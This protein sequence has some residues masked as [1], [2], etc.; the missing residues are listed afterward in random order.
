MLSFAVLAA[1][2]LAE[3]LFGPGHLRGP[4]QSVTHLQSFR[5]DLL[6]PFLPN[7]NQLLAPAAAVRAAAAATRPTIR[8]GGSAELGGY[9]GIPLVVLVL[10]LIVVLRRD[11]VI[12]ALSA[13]ATAA[14]LLSLGN[15]LEVDGRITS[16]PLP[17]AV[18][19]HLP[20]LD[21]TVPARFGLFVALFT[22]MV[23]AIGI[24]RVLVG[25]LMIRGRPAPPAVVAG[26]A[27][28]AVLT[29]VA[30]FPRTPLVKEEPALQGA[31]TS[32]LERDVPANAV[33]LTYPY[34]DPPYDVAMLWQASAKMRFRLMG[35]Y[36]TVNGAASAGQYYPVL[37]EPSFVQEELTSVEAGRSL[38]YPAVDP[39]TDG[40]AALCSYLARYGVGAVVFA[41]IAY[42]PAGPGVTAVARLFT[43]AL[44]APSTSGAGLRIW[45]VHA[46]SIR[47]GD[48][49]SSG[50]C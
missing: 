25:E 18:L 13:L 48:G 4:L 29:L 8:A 43:E 6:E 42:S 28:L 17:E 1:W 9:L 45:L 44:G 33:V 34:P 49:P 22:A 38:H 41:P 16:I 36:A 14:F 50:R 46:A 31:V 11:R 3:M 19:A 30:L 15:R 35:G 7:A 21:D 47:E 40:P 37:L 10:V 26:L 20:L 24:D 23:L 39:T 27:G 2:P 5:A 32:T 12:L